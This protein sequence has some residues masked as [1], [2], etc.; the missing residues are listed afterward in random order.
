M[1]IFTLI[2]KI[3]I[4]LYSNQFLV[5]KMLKYDSFLAIFW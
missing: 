1:Q 4:V 5:V 3:T 2:L